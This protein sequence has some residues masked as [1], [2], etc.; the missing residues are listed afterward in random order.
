M[1]DRLVEPTYTDVVDMA[2]ILLL[3]VTS[4]EDL[5]TLDLS[6]AASDDLGGSEAL[7]GCTCR[8]RDDSMLAWL[9]SRS[10][11]YESRDCCDRETLSYGE[12][13]RWWR[14]GEWR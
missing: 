8:C 6:T 4:S 14:P 10:I 9:K 7:E 12:V 1:D 5:R 11:L 3:S 2:E 13:E